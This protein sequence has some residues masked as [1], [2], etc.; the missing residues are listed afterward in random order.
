MSK[1]TLMLILIVFVVIVGPLLTIWALNTLFPVLAIP[2]SIETWFATVI[3]AG[4][5][6]GDGISFKG[7]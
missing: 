5:F 1:L 7:K 3:I 4:I 6:R 2:Y